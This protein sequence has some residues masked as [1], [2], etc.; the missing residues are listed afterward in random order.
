MISAPHAQPQLH[1]CLQTESGCWIDYVEPDPDQIVLAD[2]A[3]GLSRAPRFAGQT[4]H[5]FSVAQHSMLVQRLLPPTVPAVMHVVAL[6]H[7]GAE[8]YMGDL[9]SPLKRLL[10]AYKAIEDRLLRCIYTRFG[11]DPSM[12]LKPE[13]VAIADE[14]ALQLENVH[15]RNDAIRSEHFAAALLTPMAPASAAA[16]FTTRLNNALARCEP[17]VRATIKGPG[18]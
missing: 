6:L 3:L 18:L 1:H 13:P 7:D 17:A 12:P 9:P 16:Y 10:P 14:Q 5:F 11:V 4:K 2:I 15:L 8:A